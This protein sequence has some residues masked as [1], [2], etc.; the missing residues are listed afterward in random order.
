M[1]YVTTQTTGNAVDFGDLTQGRTTSGMANATRGVFASGDTNTTFYNVL[2]YVT[3]QTTGNA[4]DF[5]DNTDT[6]GKTGACS[7]SAS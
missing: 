2:D 3:I 7:G 6:Y 5:G 4:V 1:D